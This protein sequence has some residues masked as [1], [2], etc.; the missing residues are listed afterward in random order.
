MKP[1]VLAVG[2]TGGHLLPAL[3][4]K[5]RLAGPVWLMGR[6]L[7]THLLTQDLKQTIEIPSANNNPF[8]LACGLCKSLWH[9]QRLCPRAVIGFGSYH[10]LPVC[11][12]ALVLRIPLHLYEYN[13]QAGKVSRWLSR[14]A[15]SSGVV[16][17]ETDLKGT[18]HIVEPLLM[19]ENRSSREEAAAYFGLDPK[20]KTLL[21]FGGS[22][23]AVFLNR[24]AT[25]IRSFEKMWQVLHLTGVNQEGGQAEN[26]CV[27][28]FEARMDLAWSLADFALCR[29]GAGTICEARAYGVPAL[30]VP[31]PYAGA[32]QKANAAL[33]EQLGLGACMEESRGIEAIARRVEELMEREF[34]GAPLSKAPRFEEIVL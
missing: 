25:K 10:S 23:G 33:M 7:R 24:V 27:R 26:W 34:K 9:L 14:F 32:H 12:A 28:S 20:K 3:A 5:N 1:W 18:V 16:F 6:G 13:V 8:L 21:I 11:L 4:L 2:G 22:Q 29:A 31:Y 15:R 19:H 30:F 17:E